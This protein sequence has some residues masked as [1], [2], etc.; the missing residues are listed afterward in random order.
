[1]L[2]D[3]YKKQKEGTK[4]A[5]SNVFYELMARAIAFLCGGVVYL[6]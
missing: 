6:M 2:K 3:K 4:D 5:V 1:M